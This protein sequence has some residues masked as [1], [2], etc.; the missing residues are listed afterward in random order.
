MHLQTAIRPPTE[1]PSP[2][3]GLLS[4]PGLRRFAAHPSREFVPILVEDAA[5]DALRVMPT[6][7]TDC[8]DNHRR[9]TA[10]RS[11]DLPQPDLAKSIPAVQ[12]PRN[13]AHRFITVPDHVGTA[14][15]AGQCPAPQTCPIST[16]THGGTS[17]T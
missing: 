16:R 7:T 3:A 14:S 13:N 12:A 9:Q 8:D 10:G 6:A 5:L 4:L 1:S 15:S 2:A 11:G 17:S